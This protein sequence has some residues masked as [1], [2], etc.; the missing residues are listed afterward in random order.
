MDVER[1]ARR[2]AAAAPPP[3]TTPEESVRELSILGG[4]LI[5]GHRSAIQP[6][7]TQTE[8]W[9]RILNEMAP[10]GAET[11]EDCP[12]SNCVAS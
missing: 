11:I 3:P 2:Q 7:E 5:D 8:Q 10:T 6:Y 9:K 1:L 4:V 12:M